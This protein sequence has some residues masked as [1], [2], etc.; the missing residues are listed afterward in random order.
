[1]E[2]RII[3]VA[4][5]VEAMVS[6]RPYRPALTLEAALTEIEAGKG[7]LYD[8]KAAE[9]CITLF[10]ESRFGFDTAETGA[11]QELAYSGA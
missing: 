2:A 11:P 6:E 4:D 10:R 3:G 1:M 8:A 7:N 5:V 9:A